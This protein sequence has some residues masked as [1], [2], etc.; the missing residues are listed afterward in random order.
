MRVCAC[1]C[2]RT[3]AK[4]PCVCTYRKA[5][6]PFYEEVA[7]FL[8]RSWSGSRSIIF[9]LYH[10]H[11]LHH[12][13]RSLPTLLNTHTHTHAHTYT[14]THTHVHAFSHKMTIVVATTTHT[15]RHEDNP[16]PILYVNRFS[17]TK[18]PPTPSQNYPHTL[19][20]Q[21]LGGGSSRGQQGVCLYMRTCVLKRMCVCGGIM[22]SQW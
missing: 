11:A 12:H 3:H 4:E 2:M 13:A 18:G 5:L 21:P 7:C 1:V 20:E 22:R 14:H 17:L 10:I 19:E 16:S 9:M 15:H 6:T 8:P